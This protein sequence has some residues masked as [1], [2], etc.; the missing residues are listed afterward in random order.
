M[1]NRIQMSPGSPMIAGFWVIFLLTCPGET[2]G[3]ASTTTTKEQAEKQPLPRLD[4]VFDELRKGG[5]VVYFRHGLSEQSAATD[6]AA[7]LKKCETQRNLSVQG[8]EQMT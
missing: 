2:W 3:Q 8:S 4:A 6:E 1:R 7:D 5:L